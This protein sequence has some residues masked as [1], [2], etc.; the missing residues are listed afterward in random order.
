MAFVV[1]GYERSLARAPVCTTGLV[2]GALGFLGDA[3]AQRLE[4]REGAEPP[5]G[6]EVRLF[7]IFKPFWNYIL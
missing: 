5:L 7:S 2:A 3:M 6:P 1:R 4:S